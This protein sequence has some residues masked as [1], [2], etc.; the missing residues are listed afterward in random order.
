MTYQELVNNINKSRR[1]SNYINIVKRQA[2]YAMIRYNGYIKELQA[3]KQ[4][5][6]KEN[7]NTDCSI[8]IY[9]TKSKK[10]VYLTRYTKLPK[11]RTY[12]QQLAIT[13]RQLE[14]VYDRALRTKRE[15]LLIEHDEELLRAQL[16]I[17]NENPFTEY[18]DTINY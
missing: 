4:Y 1:Q 9:S 3:T 5:Y 18:S 10:A 11:F 12:K 6:I 14:K 13:Y 2:Y 8:K 7:I 17:E 16:E 15:H